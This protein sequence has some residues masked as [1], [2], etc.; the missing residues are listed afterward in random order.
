MNEENSQNQ[1]SFSEFIAQ[2]APPAPEPPQG[3]KKEKKGGFGRGFIA[4]VLVMLVLTVAAGLL[5]ALMLRHAFPQIGSFQNTSPD[6]APQKT[7]IDTN[8]VADKLDLLQYYVSQYY[9]FDED[10]AASEEAVYKGFMDSLGDPYTVYYTET[11]YTALQS[12]FSGTFCGIGALIQ[13][14]PETKESW[15]VR[16]FDDSPAQK[17]GVMAGDIF[18][19]VDG[20]DVTGV[21]L[22]TLAGQYVRG[23]KGTT[24][25]I[26]FLRGEER[27]QISFDIVRDTIVQD[28]VSATMREGNIGYIEIVQFSETTTQQYR[29][30]VDR[31]IAE[32]AEALVIDLRDNPGGL[33]DVAADMLDYT[34]PDGLLV[35]TADKN[36]KGSQ[37]FSDDG[38]QID[39][40][41]VLL[42]NGNSASA[43][44]IFTGAMMDF[45]RAEVVGTQTF[46]KGIVQVILPL[47]DGSG[48]KITTEHY[49]TP[50]GFDLHGEGLKPDIE[51][52]LDENCK[53][54]GDE[55]DSQLNEAVRLLKEKPE[56]AGRDAA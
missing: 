16:V 22:D 9:L 25:H 18:W 26:V 6:S 10:G 2:P 32:G 35:Y 37:Y 47:G 28:M 43:S 15:I 41:V 55:N 49:Y 20:I 50:S 5:G 24:V 13:Q 51:V 4:G 30:A 36:G 27:E 12:D 19:T 42:V 54:Y 46:G 40:P 56:L 3:G 38:H 53:V 17:A 45:G 29:E 31:M 44:E 33:V 48:V 52:E 8:A 7:E 14:D 1:Q 39:L 23:E 11:E 21:D 34:L